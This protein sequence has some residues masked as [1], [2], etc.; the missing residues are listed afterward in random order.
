MSTATADTQAIDL[1][2]GRSFANGFP[3]PH[4]TW[5]RTNAPIYWHEPTAHSPQ[6]EGF[7]VIARH[8]DC[9]A[10]ITDPETYSSD[11]GGSRTEGGRFQKFAPLHDCVSSHLEITRG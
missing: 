6:G 3:H 11:K 5:A 4:F 10:V 2:D 1:S 9:M 7:W 8:E